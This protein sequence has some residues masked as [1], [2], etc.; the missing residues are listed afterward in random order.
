MHYENEEMTMAIYQEHML[1]NLQA[2]SMTN[3]KPQLI[4][5]TKKSIDAVRT[6]LSYFLK[7]RKKSP[8]YLMIYQKL[9]DIN[10]L[11]RR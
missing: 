2:I 1:R 10:S 7:T 4:L 3:D 11:W 5:K 6:K 8:R 9:A